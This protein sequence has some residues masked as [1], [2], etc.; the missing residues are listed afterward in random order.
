MKLLGKTFVL[1]SLTAF[2]TTGCSSKKA[3]AS[4]DSASESPSEAASPK[5]ADKPAPPKPKPTLDVHDASASDPKSTELTC[6]GCSGGVRVD[7][8]LQVVL[9]FKSKDGDVVQIGDQ[10][11]KVQGGEAKLTVATL[12]FLAKVPLDKMSDGVAIPITITPAS[13]EFDK[14]E[15]TIQLEG[16]KLLVATY[17]AAA[18]MPL[19]FPGDKA[20]PTGKP[21]A[22]GIWYYKHPELLGNA[23]TLADVDVIALE[24]FDTR[25]VGSCAYGGADGST[26]SVPLLANDRVDKIYDRRTGKLTTERRFSAPPAVCTETIKSSDTSVDS[27]ADRDDV[28]K[29]RNTLID[30]VPLTDTPDAPAV[31]S[32]SAEPASRASAAPTGDAAAPVATPTPVAANPPPAPTQP[33]QQVAANPPPTAAPPTPKPAPTPTERRPRLPVLR[34]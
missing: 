32:A 16:E 33:P 9:A 6:T 19:T 29:W 13:P 14:L 4:N 5:S 10:Q 11:A 26:R 2:T 31:A 23:R 17:K 25:T 20:A 34:K 27:F 1:L 22:M 30:I 7:D 15:T 3:E 28:M 8:K 12:P 21:H 18:R 24:D